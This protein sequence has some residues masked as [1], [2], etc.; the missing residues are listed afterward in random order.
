M[1]AAFSSSQCRLGFVDKQV[2]DQVDLP[3]VFGVEHVVD[4][5]E[6]DVLVAAA[7]A[8]DVVS[9]EQFVVVEAGVCFRQSPTAVSIISLLARA[10][11][12]RVRDI[13]EECEA[14]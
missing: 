5:G 11:V 1:V 8:G 12:G 7:V 3:V 6:A 14:G 2:L 10:R 4:G 13:V 9:V